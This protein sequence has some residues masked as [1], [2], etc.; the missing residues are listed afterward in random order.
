VCYVGYFGGEY[1][2]FEFGEEV[3]RRFGFFVLLVERLEITDV[4][5]FP[6]LHMNRPNCGI[7]ASISQNERVTIFVFRLSLSWSTGFVFP[8]RVLLIAARHLFSTQ[9]NSNIW[10]FVCIYIYVLRFT[11]LPMIGESLVGA[12]P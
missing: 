2:E 4:L 10:H 11:L 7:L 8:W 1:E 6:S 9:L 5:S 12:I 3:R